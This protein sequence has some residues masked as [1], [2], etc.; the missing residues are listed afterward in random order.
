MSE[1]REPVF[2]EHC[3]NCRVCEMV[4][5]FHHTGTFGYSH[6]SL[7]IIR[8]GDGFGVYLKQPVTC[9]TC[10]GEGVGNLQ[11]VK[12]CHRAPESLRAFIEQV[13]AAAP[14]AGK[15]AEEEQ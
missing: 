14:A 10:E 9:D 1:T 5:Q 3:V 7:R 11:C 2:L 12:Y 4:C 13:A 8:S 6:S 15:E